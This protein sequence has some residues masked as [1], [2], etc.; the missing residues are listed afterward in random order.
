MNS[1]LPFI[2]IIIPTFN[3]KELL[4]KAILSVLSQKNLTQ[5]DWELII[6]DDWSNDWTK[7]YIEKYLDQ[8]KDNIIYFYQENSWVWKARN[9]WLDNVSK[10]SDYLIFLDSDDELK[11]DC[12]SFFLDKFQNSWDAKIL[13][14]YFLCE[15][16]NWNIIWNK[17]ILNWKSIIFFD[18][19]SFLSWKINTEMWLITKSSIFQVEPKLRF[20]EDIITEW[21][22]WS[23]MWQYMEKNNLKIGLYDYIWRLY[24]INHDWE[25]KITKTITKERFR[26]NAIWNERVLSIIWNDLLR[27]NRKDIYADYLFR[28]WVNWILFWDKNKWIALIKEALNNNFSIKHLFILTISLVS[29]RLLL[30]IYKIYI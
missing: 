4:E 23:K 15:D 14:Y 24:N 25:T 18:Y 22:M 11:S 10:I 17:K 16:E 7:M 1:K 26:K 27:I 12:V 20:E 28:T 9:V 30:Y 13:W 3:R 29:S 19:I 2:S 5:F 6:V 8:Y 21:V